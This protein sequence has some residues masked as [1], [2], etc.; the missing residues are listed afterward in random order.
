MKAKREFKDAP[1][2]RQALE[3]RLNDSALK[4]LVL[5]LGGKEIE[6]VGRDAGPVAYSCAEATS[7]T[8]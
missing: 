6:Q 1:A 7:P 4:C 2:F 3:A 8:A 5:M